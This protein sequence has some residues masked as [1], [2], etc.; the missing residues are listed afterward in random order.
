MSRSAFA[1]QFMKAFGQSP[2]AMLKVVRLKKA[3]ELLATTSFPAAE[4]AKWS[5]FRVEATSH[6][7]LSH[8]TAWTLV[9]SEAA[10]PLSTSSQTG[11]SVLSGH[12]EG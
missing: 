10:L 2:M 5:A 7:H 1:A 3:T 8:C 12:S 9:R 6:W 4:V 11:G